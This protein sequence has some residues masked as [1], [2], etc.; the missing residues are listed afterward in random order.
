MIP[1]HDLFEVHMNPDDRERDITVLF[2][3]Q[4]R[5]HPNHRIGP[6]VHDYFLLHTVFEGKGT[7]TWGGQ[8]YSCRT[9]DT[10]VIF[11]EG[12]FTYEADSLDPW[13]Y[14]WVALRGPGSFGSWRM[15]A[16]RRINRW[17]APGS[18]RNYGSFTLACDHRSA[19]A[20]TRIWKASRRQ[21]G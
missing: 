1:E 10:F 9:G 5:P 19:K 7:Y 8:E 17:L 16:L 20:I 13:H 3:G 11:P 6:S 12:L 2:S 14:A 21:A 15:S 18:R 4:G